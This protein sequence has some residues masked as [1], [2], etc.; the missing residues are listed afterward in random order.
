MIL[1][2]FDYLYWRIFYTRFHKTYKDN[3]LKLC[4]YSLDTS[5]ITVYVEC[6]SLHI[7]IL[8]IFKDSY[9]KKHLI[10]VNHDERFADKINLEVYNTNNKHFIYIYILEFSLKILFQYYFHFTQFQNAYHS[11]CT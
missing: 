7:E 5:S 3:I 4:W 2:L 9:E 1:S 6:A 8:F 11:L 10:R